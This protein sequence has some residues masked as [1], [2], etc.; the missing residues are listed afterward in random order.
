MTNTVQLNSLTGSLADWTVTPIMVNTTEA[1][2]IKTL[3]GTVQNSIGDKVDSLWI[4][5]ADDSVL[6]N[7]LTGNKAKWVIEPIPE[8]G[9]LG[10]ILSTSLVIISGRRFFMI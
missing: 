10:L 5:G 3:N 8:P 9:P 7:D 6:I 1:F 2:Y 4:D